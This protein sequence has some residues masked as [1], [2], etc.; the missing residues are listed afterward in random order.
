MASYNDLKNKPK[1]N[2]VEVV[3]NKSFLDYNICP[4]MY[5]S[6]NHMLYT[7]L[8]DGTRVD[9]KRVTNNPSS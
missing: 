8:T 3:G 6:V 9:I 5:D 4:L 2:N 7:I 1:I